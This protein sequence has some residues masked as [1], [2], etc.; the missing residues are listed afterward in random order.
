V[1]VNDGDQKWRIS[2]GDND[3]ANDDIMKKTG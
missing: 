3:G 1:D 2:D